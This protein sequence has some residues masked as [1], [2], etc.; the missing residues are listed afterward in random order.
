VTQ[1]PHVIHPHAVYTLAAAQLALG[2]PKSTLRREVRLGRLR[3]SK[4]AGRYFLL[5]AWLLEWLRSGEILRRHAL[6]VTDDGA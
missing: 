6:T 5:G 4:R 1:E 3:V 2:L